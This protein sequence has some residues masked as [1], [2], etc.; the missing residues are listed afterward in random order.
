MLLFGEVGAAGGGGD[1]GSSDGGITLLI[2]IL[3][4]S[5]SYI[6]VGPILPVQRSQLPASADVRVPLI[7]LLLLLISIYDTL[8]KIL[9]IALLIIDRRPRRQRHT[10][11]TFALWV[12]RSSCRLACRWSS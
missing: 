7:L 10:W 5:R 4:I 8:G 6:F 9:H 3:H 11:H 2:L 12:T 1:G